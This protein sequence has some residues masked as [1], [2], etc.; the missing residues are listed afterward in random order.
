VLIKVL[1]KIEVRVEESSVVF[2]SF[3]ALVRRDSGLLGI[4]F[5][6]LAIS[7]RLIAKG[8]I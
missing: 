6:Q 3:V 7:S 8:R 4:A 2:L 1:D 5:A